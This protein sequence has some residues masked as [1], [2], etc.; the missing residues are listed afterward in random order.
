MKNI[1][2]IAIA[3]QKGGACK[4]TTPINLGASLARH[5]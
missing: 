3:I 2:I 1:Q 4:I 5:I